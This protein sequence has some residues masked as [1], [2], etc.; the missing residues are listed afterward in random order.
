LF[1]FDCRRC[2]RRPPRPQ[3]TLLR[4]DFVL[5]ERRLVPVDRDDVRLCNDDRPHLALDGDATAGRAV[6]GREVGDVVALPRVGGLDLRLSALVA[7]RR[8]GQR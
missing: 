1:A 3:V 4:A 6:E 7:R 2:R 8:R 5:G